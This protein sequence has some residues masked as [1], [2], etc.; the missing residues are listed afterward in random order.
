[1]GGPGSV[2][3]AG[4]GLSDAGGSIW[5]SAKDGATAVAKGVERGW[6]SAVNDAKAAGSWIDSGET[7]LENKIDEGRGWLREH[8]GV[9]GRVASHQIGVAEG[10]GVSVYDAGKG[11]V[12]FADGA[13]SLANPIEWAADPGANIARV[14]ST[15]AS[16]KALGR[17]AYLA[18]PLGWMLDPQGSAQFAGTL[19]NSA[20][21]SFESDPAKFVGNAVGT[22]GMSIG[23]AEAAGAA[24]LA[25]RVARQAP[26]VAEL[27]ADVGEAATVSAD[28]GKAA[29][30][31]RDA[32]TAAEEFPEGIAY[33]R[34]LPRHLKGPGG[35]TNRGQLKGTHNLEIATKRFNAKGVT[36]SVKPT[37]T[38][39][40]SV[41]E[42]EYTDRRK[43]IVNAGRKTVYDPKVIDDKTMLELAQKAGRK[44]FQQYLQNPAQ[45]ISEVT[46]GGIRF[47]V[48]II[49]DRHGR[50][51]I[52]GNAHPIE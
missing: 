29:A 26:R 45:N 35:F 22:I 1:M 24:G 37:G 8:G 6:K 3:S 12:Q 42:Y 32:G 2:T 4:H 19:W 31:T 52:I 16:V 25:A 38:P 10:V 23:G 47:R 41:L 50:N 21:R 34:D 28:T 11:L 48:Y 30:V 5:N 27:A 17:I 51:P 18:S 36:Y 15:V 40:I 43:G 33:R 49:N 14:K 44:P 13:A 20:A 9:A 39:G 46:E 7:Y